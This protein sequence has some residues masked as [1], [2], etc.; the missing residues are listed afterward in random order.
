MQR[1]EGKNKPPQGADFLK[2]KHTKWWRI[3]GCEFIGKDW[4][5]LVDSQRHENQLW[6]WP[7]R[8]TIKHSKKKL[9]FNI[10]INIGAQKKNKILS[11]WSHIIYLYSL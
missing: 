11:Y 9:N 5:G 10:G 6:E 8:N 4:S 7:T 3:P 1:V 2:K